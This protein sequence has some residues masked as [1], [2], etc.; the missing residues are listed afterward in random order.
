MSLTLRAPAKINLGLRILGRRSDGFHDLRGVFQEI[1]LADEI[2]IDIRPGTGE[3]SLECTDPDIPSGR[4]NL[5]WKAAEAVLDSSEGCFDV[6]MKLRKR[7]PSRAGLGGG[8]SDAA[9]VLKTLASHA[10]IDSGSMISI[11]CRLGSDVPFFLSGGAAMVEGRGERITPIP[12]IPFHAVL[13]HPKV[14]ISTPWAYDLWDRESKPY[15]TT[16]RQIRHYSASSA[17]WHEGKPYPHD[18][19]NDFL[20]LLEEHIPEIAELSRFLG[21]SKVR[22]W[23][24]SGSGPTFYTLFRTAQQACDLLKGLRWEYTCCRSAG[25]AGAS[26]NG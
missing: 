13:I 10:G 20:P 6:K 24:L 3:I 2:R 23:G 7:I 25:S 22:N 11:A 14:E 15:L 5:V 8:S 18:L 16:S 21:E 26:S 1:D 9:A 4:E 19:R 17:V 12:M